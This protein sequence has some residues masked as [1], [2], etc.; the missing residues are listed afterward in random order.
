MVTPGHGPFDDCFS[1]QEPAPRI[2]WSDG[3]SS[4]SQ[5]LVDIGSF[6]MN[7]ATVF[8]LNLNPPHPTLSTNSTRYRIA[9]QAPKSFHDVALVEEM[10]A[11]SRLS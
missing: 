6:T 2:D 4:K 8:A 1:G 9:G 3:W 11:Q 5:A 7:R 10:S